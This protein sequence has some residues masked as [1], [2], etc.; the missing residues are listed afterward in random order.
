MKKPTKKLAWLHALKDHLGSNGS[1]EVIVLGRGGSAHF[2]LEQHDVEQVFAHHNRRLTVQS[3]I[4]QTAIALFLVAF[5]TYL[6]YDFNE[7]LVVSVTTGK[8][9]EIKAEK[10]ALATAFDQ[11]KLVTKEVIGDLNADAARQLDALGLNLDQVHAAVST[12]QRPDTGGPVTFAEYMNPQTLTELSYLSAASQ[13][14]DQLPTTNPMRESRLTSGFGMR[15]HPI[16]GQ[17]VPHRGI[18]LVSWSDPLVRATGAGRV[19]FAADNG[20]AGLMVTIDHGS[21][22]STSYMHLAEIQ[23]KKNDYLTEGDTL[24]IMGDTGATTGPH[25]HYEIKL[26]DQHLNPKSVFRVATNDN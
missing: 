4:Y 2:Q 8:V 3:R 12:A 11:Y 25:L 14:F 17:I 15:A 23:I 6:F 10:A 5:C 21:G 1:T 19:S 16:T 26:A 20:N 18:D 22:L 24:G 7:R 9:A 13:F